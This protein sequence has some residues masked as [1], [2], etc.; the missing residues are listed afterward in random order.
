MR[1]FIIL[2]C[3]FT[4]F[5]FLSTAS[6]KELTNRL[7]VGYSNQFSTTLP[8]VT[9]RYYPNPDLG[10]QATLG[11]D[12]ETDASKFGL[13]VKGF[14]IIFTEP[15][16]NFYLGAGAAIVSEEVS[17]SSNSGFELNGYIGM[18]FFIQGLDSLGFIA[19][20]G[21]GITS[22]DSGVRFRSFGDHPFT[23]GIVFYF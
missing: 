21:I 22:I 17:G 14:K 20:A 9:A 23:A 10:V 3:L 13:M 11:I 12:T 19:E 8:G 2:I 4:T 18:E 5:G 1:K 16:M 6:S 15:N 7:G